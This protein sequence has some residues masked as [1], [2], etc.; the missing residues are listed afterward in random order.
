MGELVK[1]Q[2]PTN[3]RGFYSLTECVRDIVEKSG[4]RSG[5][6]LLFLPHTSA[7]L[8]IQET[9]DPTS[10]GDLERFMVSLGAQI[11]YDAQHTWESPEDSISHIRAAITGCSQTMII[12]NGRLIL[13]DWQGVFLWEHRH[14]PRQRNV[15]I[16]IMADPACAHL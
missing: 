8:V 16:K 6:A 2:V 7:S 1:L 14:A 5:I 13:G 10:R 9:G 12:E 11:Q 4:I 3:G 15:F